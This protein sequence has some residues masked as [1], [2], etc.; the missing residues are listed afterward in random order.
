LHRISARIGGSI[1]KNRRALSRRE[2]VRWAQFFDWEFEHR[3][4]WELYLAEITYW[5]RTACGYS[6][7]LATCYHPPLTEKIADD[8]DLTPENEV[9]A[10]LKAAYLRQEQE[11]EKE[12]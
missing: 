8:D 3:E 9:S 2:K 11:K 1:E 4:K 6:G 12:N 10:A 5:L 7:D